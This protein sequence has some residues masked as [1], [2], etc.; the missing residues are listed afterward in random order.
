MLALSLERGEG[1]VDMV[2]FT[3]QYWVSTTGRPS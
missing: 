3:I 2:V 1:L